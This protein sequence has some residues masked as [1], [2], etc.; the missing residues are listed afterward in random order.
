MASGFVKAELMTCRQGRS[1]VSCRLLYNSVLLLVFGL[2]LWKWMN[3]VDSLGSNQEC[4]IGYIHS[5][6][7]VSQCLAS[8]RKLGNRRSSEGLRSFKPSKG[9]NLFILIILAGD[10]EMNPG[11]RFQCGLCKKY[12]KASDRLLECEECEKRFHASCSNLSDNELLR[13][14]SGDGAWYCTNCKADCGLCSGAVLKGHKA[15]QCDNC[16]M[17]I[18]NECS[19]IAETQYETVNNTNCT[20]ICPKCEFFNFSDSFFGEQVNV[21]TENRFVPLTKVKKDRSSPCGTNKSSFISGLKFISMNINSIRGKKLELLAFLDFHQ[22][23]VVA[24]QE[25]KIDSSIATSELFPETCPYSVYRKD[26]NIHGGG[27]M[28]LVHKD[29]SHMPITELENDS[30]SIWV[31]VFANKTSHFVASWYRPPGSTSEEFQLFREQ[32]DYIRTHHKGKKLP[33]AHVLGDFNFKDI[34]WPDRLSK[35]GSTL[36]QSEGQILIDIMNDHG[37]EQMVHFPTREKNTLDLILT[38]LPGQFQ[39][40]HSPDKLSDHDIVSGTLKMFIP[41]IKKPRRKVYLYQKGDYES[42]RKDTLQFSKE[43]YFN[44]HS[45]TRSVQENFDLLT[46]FIQ[47]SADKHIPSKTSRSVSSIPWITPEIRRKIRRKNKT[48]AKAKKTGSSKLRSKF[49]TLRR[50]IKADVRKQ[51]DLYV[52]NLVGDVKA[53]PR[54]FYRYINSQ[55]KDTQGIPPLKRKN[56]KGVAQSDLEKAE[57][58]NGQF[59]DVFSKN[60]HTQVPLLDRSAPF[61]NDI[62]VSKDGVIKLLK[63]LNPSKALGPDELHPRVLKELATELGPVLAHLFQQSI[64]T[65]EIPKEWSLANICPLFKKSDRSLACNYRPV[66]LTCVPCKLLEHIVCSNIMAHLD[67]YKL[68]SDRQHAFRKGHSCETQLTTVI[69]DWAKILD[70][71]G[72]VDTFILDF[73]KAF[74]TPPHELL[75][76]KLFGYGIGGKTL[77]WIDSFLCFRQ[78]RVVVNGVKSDWAPVLSGVPQGTVLGPLLFSLYINDISSDIESEIRLFADDCV[79]YR[80]IKDEKDTMKLQRDIDR[81]GSWARKWGMRFQP[82]KCNMMQLTRKRIKKIHASYTLEGTNLENVE[83]IKY[84]GVTI[85]SDLRWNTHVSNVCTKANRTLGFLR[86]NLHSCPQEVKEAAYK[87][88]VRPVLDYGSSVWDPPGVVLQEELESVQKRAAR[89]VTGNYDYETGSMTGILGQLKWESLKKR[90]KDNRLILLYKGLKG[91]ASVPTDDLIPKTRRCRNQHSMAFQTPIANTDVYKGSFFPQ[92]I[93][94]WNALPDSLISSAE[95]A[96]DCV[97]KFTSLVRARD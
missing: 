32:L 4:K 95:D 46:S 30:E 59:T 82:V 42:M 45:D 89:F 64:D 67:E 96:E 61:M 74:D 25:T 39:D 73:E 91:K 81:L 35:S 78:Q 9:T 87:G 85:T 19:F 94:D 11:P 58:F 31:K 43:K 90:R 16:D 62:A 14:E 53:N 37:L 63:G 68:L 2:I 72:Q 36:S 5:H 1:Q 57:E 27:V 3:G 10:I 75:K 84:L 88:L 17:W 18:H 7:R 76:S 86:R 80:E 97:A 21:E 77:K 60:E 15:V 22:P 55:K 34:D 52:N 92:T 41:P 65:G 56:G 6:S 51:H 54:D 83:S 44:G 23:H 38:T 93:R 49:E 47:D 70:N 29:I 66:S 26:R 28:L 48:H 12:C 50:E 33:S 79:C 71:R 24:I 13:I 8:I 69:N 40:V 20:W